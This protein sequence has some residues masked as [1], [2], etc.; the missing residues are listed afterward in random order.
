M[1]KGRD[2][3][4]YCKIERSQICLL[5]QMKLAHLQQT[6]KERLEQRLKCLALGALLEAEGFGERSEK[7][8]IIVQG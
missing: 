3:K 8:R 1:G 5:L 2:D 6:K 7:S 4:T